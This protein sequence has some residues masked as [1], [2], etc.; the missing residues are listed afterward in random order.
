MSMHTQLGFQDF[1]RKGF[2]L[3]IVAEAIPYCLGLPPL[4]LFEHYKNA[5]QPFTKTHRIYSK[6]VIQEKLF[7]LKSI[8]N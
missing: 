4:L 2:L 5:P 6:K 8:L 1:Y 7:T 3:K